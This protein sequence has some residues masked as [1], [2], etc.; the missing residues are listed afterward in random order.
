M[1]IC[2]NAEVVHAYLLKCCRGTFS[3]FGMLKG[4]MVRERLGTPVLD[5]TITCLIQLIYY[6]CSKDTIPSKH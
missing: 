5:G 4:Y 3:S 1:F 6:L 2:R